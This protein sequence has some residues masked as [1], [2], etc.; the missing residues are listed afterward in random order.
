MCVVLSVFVFSDG[1][2]KAS[3]TTFFSAFQECASELAPLVPLTLKSIADYRLI[4]ETYFDRS[5]S[6]RERHL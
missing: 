2:E 5:K 6:Y 3:Q 1:V 4:L